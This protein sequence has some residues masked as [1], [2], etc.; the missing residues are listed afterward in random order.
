MLNQDLHGGQNHPVIVISTKNQ[1]VGCE[2]AQ[3][4]DGISPISRLLL[5]DDS[6]S[7]LGKV[8]PK[9]GA[10]QQAGSFRVPNALAAS[11]SIKLHQT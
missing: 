4:R 3:F 11:Y 9:A 6:L 8:A 2:S 10:G 7:S 1:E 5:N